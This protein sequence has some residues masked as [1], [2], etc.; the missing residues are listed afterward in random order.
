[1][2]WRDDIKEAFT[3]FPSDVISAGQKSYDVA[4]HDNDRDLEMSRRNLLQLG[5][6]AMAAGA[7]SQIPGAADKYSLRSPVAVDDDSEPSENENTDPGGES[8]T[9]EPT[10]SEPD[11]DYSSISEGLLE[12]DEGA[13]R[14]FKGYTMTALDHQL[15]DVSYGDAIENTGEYESEIMEALEGTEFEHGRLRVGE[16]G[17][18]DDRPDGRWLDLDSVG[19]SEENRF[20][21]YLENLEDEGE[22]EDEVFGY[23]DDLERSD[24]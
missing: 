3:K 24:L 14:A 1:M 6:S 7:A 2:A 9:D 8:G 18:T 4:R 10:S 22:L 5:G 11:F 16:Y 21:D 15:D 19:F 20:D 12:E 17:V 13:R 23:L